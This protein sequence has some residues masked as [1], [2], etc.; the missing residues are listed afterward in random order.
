MGFVG[1]VVEDFG[2]IEPDWIVL[3]RSGGEVVGGGKYC[4][5]FS[6]TIGMLGLI[7]KV[8]NW[9]GTGT[10]LKRRLHTPYKKKVSGLKTNYL[11]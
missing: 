11:D 6:Y 8:W 3:E 9:Y 1:V 7:T 2:G 10:E 5:G 4:I